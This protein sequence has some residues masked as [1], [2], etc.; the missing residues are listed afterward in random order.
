M[1][2]EFVKIKLCQ[3]EIAR[4]LRGANEKMKK[5]NSVSIHNSPTKVPKGT[6]IYNTIGLSVIII[7]SCFK[8]LWNS[9]VQFTGTSDCQSIVHYEPISEGKSVNKEMC[10]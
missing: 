3:M 9:L 4:N 2:D 6:N 1:N 7:H 8:H 5:K 10:H